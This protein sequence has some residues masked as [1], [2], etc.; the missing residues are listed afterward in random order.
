M[1][2]TSYIVSFLVRNE[3]EHKRALELSGKLK[4][5]ELIVTNAIL[6]E[7][8]NLLIKRLNKNTTAVME[9]YNFIK[10][11]FKIIYETRE[12]TEKAMDT[13]I[14]YDSSLGLADALT[15]V[16]MKELDIHEIF[17]FDDDFD[18]KQ[19]IVRIH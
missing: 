5:E 7:I 14:N 11:E 19:G 10:N 12:L 4:N 3:K 17:S 2:D 1:V 8:I 9:A 13:L 16:V 15:I 6:T 18:N